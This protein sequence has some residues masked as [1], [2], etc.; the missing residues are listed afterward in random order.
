MSHCNSFEKFIK[1]EKSLSARKK[2]PYLN[3]IFLL[4]KIINY[5]LE[6]LKIKEVD[7]SAILNNFPVVFAKSWFQEIIEN[8]DTLAEN[9]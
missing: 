8:M 9:N 7:F 5:K 6:K 1:R 2:E 4:K 3:F